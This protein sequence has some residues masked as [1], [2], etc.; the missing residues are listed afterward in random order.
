MSPSY[1]EYISLFLL[2]ITWH[3][4]LITKF[5]WVTVLVQG[6]GPISADG[7]TVSRILRQSRVLYSR[8]QRTSMRTPLSLIH[9]LGVNPRPQWCDLGWFPSLPQSSSPWQ[10]AINPVWVLQRTNCTHTRDECPRR[11]S[12]RLRKEKGLSP[13]LSRFQG[14]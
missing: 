4:G 10:W 8:R 2:L 3:P 12:T 1:M 11:L 7:F 6:Q 9:P 14:A 5:M 13:N